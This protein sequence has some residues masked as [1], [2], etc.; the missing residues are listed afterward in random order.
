MNMFLLVPD[1]MKLWLYQLALFVIPASIIGAGIGWFVGRWYVCAILSYAAAI[2]VCNSHY[3][4]DR[5]H[6]SF[7]LV[8]LLGYSAVLAMPPILA[9]ASAGYFVA[10][11]LRPRWTSR[12][13]KIGDHR[14]LPKAVSRLIWLGSIA[15][16]QILEFLRYLN[17]LSYRPFFGLFAAVIAA[18][19]LW[20]IAICLVSMSRHRQSRFQP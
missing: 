1:L 9:A 4:A 13:P 15:L 17:G 19:L 14:W 7:D 11:K 6:H 10:R 16:F 18:A 5:L 3:I 12:R 20:F 2:A 8:H